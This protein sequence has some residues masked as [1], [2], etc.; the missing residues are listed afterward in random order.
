MNQPQNLA[1]FRVGDVPCVGIAQLV[2]E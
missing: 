1:Q 2:A